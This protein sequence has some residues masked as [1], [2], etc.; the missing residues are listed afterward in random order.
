MTEL[1]KQ[2][3]SSIIGINPVKY[4][5]SIRH[6]QSSLPQKWCCLLEFSHWHSSILTG[7]NLIENIPIVGIF[8]QIL[9]EIFEFCLWN[10]V[11]SILGRCFQGSFSSSESSDENW[12]EF[13][14]FREL[15]D[16]P[17]TFIDFCQTKITIAID[18]K[19]RPILIWPAWIR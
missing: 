9:D 10:I 14:K 7:I 18:I 8:S 19:I 11:I 1:I 15:D 2:D 6:P 17:D 13:K 5:L 3:I 16:I 12:F 4:H